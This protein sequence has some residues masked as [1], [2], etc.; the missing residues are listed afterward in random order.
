MFVRQMSYLLALAREK[1]FTRAA[2]SCCVT[3]STLSSG[4]KALERELDLP[5]VL[6]GPRF[7]G[8]T[9]EG[10]RVAA[11]AAHIVS[12]Y[13]N[14]KQDVAGLRSGLT[15]TLRLGVV[16]AAMPAVAK[17]TAPFCA[18]YPGLSVNVL[19]LTSAEIQVGLD[20]FELDAGITYLENEPLTKVRKFPLYDERYLLVAHIDSSVAQMSSVSWHDAAAE[21][22]CL[23]N[24]SMQNRRILNNIAQS[25]GI[26][27]SPSVTSNSYLA[28]C[29]H[30]CTGEWASIIPHSF[31]YIF[32]G[33]RELALVELVGPEQFQS[34]GIVV[35][36]RDPL[37]PVAHALLRYAGR[38]VAADPLV[39]ALA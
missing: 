37:S 6:R 33:C 28:V 30:V 27:L 14:L 7:I 5:L 23:L 18:Q 38:L 10:E 16:P 35:S 25:L 39:P 20:K 3:Q 4:L 13:E 36:E 32:R 31:S 2:E 22:L 21:N 29:S 9:L 8:L 11:W 12:D 34:I 19:S 24:E 15:G 17:V 26:K 1:H